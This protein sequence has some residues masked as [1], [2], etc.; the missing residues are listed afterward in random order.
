MRLAKYKKENKELITYLLFEAGD[1]RGFIDG[2]KSEID[3]QFE[4]MNQ[5]NVYFIKKSLRKTL[6]IANKHIKYSGL[7]Q[8]EAELLI[9][10]CLK[11]KS[12]DLPIRSST[13]L[14]NLYSRQIERI[15]KAVAS[16]HEDI[17]YDFKDDIESLI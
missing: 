7:K 11:M 14:N 13:V 12:S 8:T 6:R 2:V 1:E 4:A 5:S 10:F 9:Y 15:K 3:T 17:Q 16:L